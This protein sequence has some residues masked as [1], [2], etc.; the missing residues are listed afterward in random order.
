MNATSRFLKEVNE[1]CLLNQPMD[2]VV[3]WC[4]WCRNKRHF[5][6]RCP[7]L[8]RRRHRCWKCGD[9]THVLRNCPE[10]ET[11][12]THSGPHLVVDHEVV[13]N[14]DEDFQALKPAEAELIY[15]EFG[16]NAILDL[17]EL[18]DEENG[19]AILPQAADDD[20][21]EELL[22]QA[23]ML[24]EK[25]GKNAIHEL[26]DL[27]DEWAINANRESTTEDDIGDGYLE[28]E[29]DNLR[30]MWLDLYDE[31]E[32]MEENRKRCGI[33]FW[34]NLI[35]RF[36]NRHA[37]FE[38]ATVIDRTEWEMIVMKMRRFLMNQNQD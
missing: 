5:P 15:E 28:T 38:G 2:V 16:E 3:R 6:K 8:T 20:L 13:R 14:L 12:C 35:V 37:K 33:T 26:M 11:K 10:I 27:G 25:F 34:D 9:V 18:E 24:Y 22:E 19:A 29:D 4:A 30:L 31:V 17:V 36:Q 7:T 21:V 32:W 23:L 1:Q